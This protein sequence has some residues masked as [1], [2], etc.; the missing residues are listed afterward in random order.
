M[1]R[2]DFLAAGAASAFAGKTVR[3]GIIGVGGR[4]TALLKALLDVADV[5]IPALC[6][7]DERNLNRAQTIVETG[8]KRR[9]EGY[10]Q[11]PEDFRRMVARPD[12][13]AVLVATP[14]K[15]HARMSVAAMQAG[16]YVG[17]RGARGDFG[18]GMLGPGQ[19][20]RADRQALH[21]VGECL[22]FPQRD[23][24]AQHGGAG[25]AR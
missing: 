12:L 19:Y 20:F 9:P 6:D 4:G 3:A 23:G 18:G 21:A 8:G 11:G 25:P 5:E 16:K 22:L 7:I 2:R 15:W 1:T 13:D 14:W 24:G 17:Y 10:S